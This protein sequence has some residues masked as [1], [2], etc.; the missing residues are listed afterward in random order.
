MSAPRRLTDNQVHEI[1]EGWWR[2][3][4]TLDSLAAEHGISTNAVWK[5]VNRRTYSKPGEGRV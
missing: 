4:R 1:R 5:V 2:E 3:N